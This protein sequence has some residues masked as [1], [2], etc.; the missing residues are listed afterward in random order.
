MM[1]KKKL[2]K[3]YADYQKRL[4]QI[5]EWAIYSDSKLIG[6]QSEIDDTLRRIEKQKKNKSKKKLKKM[7]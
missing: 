6:I 1:L 3:L 7:V 2:K 5:P 4:K